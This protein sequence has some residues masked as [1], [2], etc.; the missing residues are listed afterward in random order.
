MSKLIFLVYKLKNFSLQIEKE[1]R[2]QKGK[3]FLRSKVDR[4]GGTSSQMER[5]VSPSVFVDTLG[6]IN[7]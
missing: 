7:L 6:F 2:S 1:I 4:C 5:I 3:Q